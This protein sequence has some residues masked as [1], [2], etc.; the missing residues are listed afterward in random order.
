MLG[1]QLDE[2]KEHA[3]ASYRGV[4]GSGVDEDE[5]LA[6]ASG[7]ELGGTSQDERDAA[8]DEVI[9]EETEEDRAFITPHA[10]DVVR[11]R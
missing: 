3:S 4:D 10:A 11:L 9:E 8:E 2:R 7:E 5:D 1:I 6:M